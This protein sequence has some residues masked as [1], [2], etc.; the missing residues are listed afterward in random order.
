MTS[1]PED[2]EATCWGCGL[3]LLLPYSAPVFKCGW[4]GAITNQNPLKRESRHAWWWWWWRRLR[5]W[6]FLSVLLTFMLFLIVGGVWAVHP[7]ILSMDIFYE[8]FHFILITILSVSTLLTFSLAA[9]RYSGTPPSIPW[10]RYPDVGKGDFEN[11]TFCQYC[12]KPKSPRT[13]HCKSC[14]MCVL[15]MDHHCPFI[16]NCVGAANHRHFVGFL[17]SAVLSTIYVSIMAAYAALQIW[18]PMKHTALGRLNSSHLSMRIV[19]EVLASFL[20]TALFLPPRG[21]LL[22]YLFFASVSVQIGLIVL[23]WQQLCFIYAGETYFSHLVSGSDGDGRR[24]DCRNLFRFFGCPY[25]TI[26]YFPCF[27]TTGKWH[28]KCDRSH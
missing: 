14:R 13:H 15:D 21:L 17:I 6:C 11:Y 22:V 25:F 24:K 16:G 10:G 8:I 27:R 12:L 28:K 9:F 18:P 2:Q 1:I 3:R 19:K 20:N 23:L 5:D 4:C 26:R 7:I